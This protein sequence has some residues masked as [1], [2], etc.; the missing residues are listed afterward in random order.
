MYT[1]TPS[2]FAVTD[3]LSI[4]GN[5]TTVAPPGNDDPAVVRAA[6]CKAIGIVA[7]AAVAFVALWSVYSCIK[8]ACSSPPTK[9]SDDAGT[10]DLE[11]GNN[12]NNIAATNTKVGVLALYRFASG[13]DVLL[14]AAGMLCSSAVGLVWPA[15][16]VLLG[17]ILDAFVSCV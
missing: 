4:N 3:D 12:I 15:F 8:S 9:D 1:T 7:A 2:L 13:V 6:L 14:L 5:T 11:A 10:K 17:S 16:Y